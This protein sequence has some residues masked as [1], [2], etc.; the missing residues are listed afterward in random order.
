M[1]P[2]QITGGG[3][4]P[5]ADVWA[6]GAVLFEA[7]TGRRRFDGSSALSVMKAILLDAPD[8]HGLH[9]FGQSTLRSSASA[10]RPSAAELER[11]LV[12]AHRP[13]RSAP[14]A[15]GAVAPAPGPVPAKVALGTPPAGAM[16]GG[17]IMAA[18]RV[19]AVLA[20]AGLALLW[21]GAGW[22]AVLAAAGGG[23]AA[24]LVVVLT[25]RAREPGR[26]PRRRCRWHDTAA[27]ASDHA[28]VTRSI[29]LAVDELV[30]SVRRNPRANLFTASMALAID[31]YEAAT[32]SDPEKRLDATLKVLDLLMQLERR[33]QEVQAPWYVRHEKPLAFVSALGGASAIRLGC[34]GTCSAS[35]VPMP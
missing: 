14:P 21:Y 32:F 13:A 8:A 28:A 35:A 10:Q 11:L 15:G 26:L 18:L 6:L 29:A 23:L 24:A 22:P 1:A 12:E 7:L 4:G 9:P 25:R 27:L 20:L 33:M 3:V 2:E 34:R 16:A 31:G 30:A 5:A 17:A 19:G